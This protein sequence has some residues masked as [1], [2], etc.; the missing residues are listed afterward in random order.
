MF[1]KNITKLNLLLSYNL[2]K[3][4]NYVVDSQD[5]VMQALEPHIHKS[6]TKKLKN[7]EFFMSNISARFAFVKELSCVN[8]IIMGTEGSL[9]GDRRDWRD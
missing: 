6:P 7:Y 5:S 3:H 4:S 9:K 8:T 2:I 1:C